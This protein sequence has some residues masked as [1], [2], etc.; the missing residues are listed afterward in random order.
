M[1]T[2][3]SNPDRP[4]RVVLMGVSGCGKS[5]VGSALAR[6]CAAE[7]IDGD[8]LHPPGN[9]TKMGSGQPLTDGDRWPWLARVRTTLR[10]RQ[11]VVVACS[12]LARRYRDLLRQAEGTRFVFLDVTQDEAW[13][14]LGERAGHYMRPQMVVSQFE[15]LERPVEEET[16]VLTLD[17][18]LPVAELVQRIQEQLPG[19]TP[20]GRPLVSFG[21]PD[22]EITGDDLDAHLTSVVDFVAAR[23]ARR[24]LLVP[25]DH[26]RLHA[27]AGDIAVRLVDALEAGG[28][29]VGVLPALG[30][31]MA[32]SD[33]GAR[34]LF[35]DAIGADRL[36]GDLPAET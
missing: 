28:R 1:T 23:G 34:L 20:A 8:A 29:E 27:R 30:T 2:R 10:Q 7:F 25:P 32:L 11:G 21:S 9:V 24:V 13:R 19:T 16:D 12:A 31:H 3:G 4:L 36:V 15:A 17:A 14:R 6:T 22:T 18:T 33:T 26:T 35:G 5:T